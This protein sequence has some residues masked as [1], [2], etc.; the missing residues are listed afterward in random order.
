[1]SRTSLT[2]GLCNDSYPYVGMNKATRVMCRTLGQEYRNISQTLQVA[3][4]IYLKHLGYSSNLSNTL[5][6]VGAISAVVKFMI[7]QHSRDSLMNPWSSPIAL[8]IGKSQNVIKKKTQK[9]PDLQSVIAFLLLNI[10]S[11]QELII[12]RSFTWTLFPCAANRIHWTE[13]SKDCFYLQQFLLSNKVSFHFGA[14]NST[15]RCI[16]KLG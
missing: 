9:L 16:M 15:G 8:R 5:H 11:N 4:D 1:M 14:I 12:D 7:S 6:F 2:K 3:F 13:Q 10:S